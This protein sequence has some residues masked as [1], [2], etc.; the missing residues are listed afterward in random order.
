MQKFFMDNFD[1][2]LFNNLTYLSSCPMY[3]LK[4]DGMA[5]TFFKVINRLSQFY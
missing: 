1:L 5:E 4:L 2:V 3:T